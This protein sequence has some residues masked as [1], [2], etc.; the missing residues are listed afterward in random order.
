MIFLKLSK[1]S[2][3]PLGRIS[4]KNTKKMHHSRKVALS[5]LRQFLATESSLNKGRTNSEKISVQLFLDNF[6]ALI[7]K[8]LVIFYKN[9]F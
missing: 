2:M 3:D 4:L 5:G 6:G 7:P 1:S 9:D 8:I